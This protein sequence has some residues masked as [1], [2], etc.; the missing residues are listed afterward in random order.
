MT[1]DFAPRMF[2]CTY[3][4]DLGRCLGEQRQHLV[5]AARFLDNGFFRDNGSLQYICV[6]VF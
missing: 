4:P 6:H 3:V 5:L 1:T 2:F